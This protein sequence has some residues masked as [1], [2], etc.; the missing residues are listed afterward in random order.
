MKA[1]IIEDELNV[2]SG[3]KKLLQTFC[4]DVEVVGSA[5]N[6]E[7]GVALVQQTSF[8]ILFLD[9][10]LPDGSGFDLLHQLSQ[11][12]FHTI[13]VTAYDQYAID[14]FKISAV[15][16]LLKPISPDL[17][18]KAI[19]KIKHLEGL[20]VQEDQLEAIQQ[21]IEA[22]YNQHEKIILRDTEGMRIVEVSSI[23]YCEAEGSYTKFYFDNGETILTSMHLKE[24]ERLLEPYGFIRCHHSYLINLQHV[25]AVNK[26]DGGVVVLSGQISLPLSTRKKSSVV[27]AIKAR[28][29]N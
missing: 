13:F 3:F 25:L 19:E 17:L 29:I 10:N 12:D 7:S 24:Y 16:Y 23:V 9:I 4:P 14:A 26:N 22:E 15:D 18:K 20:V 2:L 21:R 8:D 1:I 6:V 28:F 27:E 11:R 5:E